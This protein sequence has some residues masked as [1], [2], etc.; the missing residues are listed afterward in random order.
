[1]PSA[2]RLLFGA[3]AC[4]MG[5]DVLLI[6]QKVPLQNP[7][8]WGVWV[9]YVI[10]FVFISAGVIA[11]IPRRQ[12]ATIQG[13]SEFDP[14]PVRRLSLYLFSQGAILLIGAYLGAQNFRGA[15]VDRVM[16]ATAAIVIIAVGLIVLLA[17]SNERVYRR[18]YSMAHVAGH[19]ILALLLLVP[20]ATFALLLTM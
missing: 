2:L 1:M 18:A 11:Y 4:F 17:S 3:S 6:M 12:P 20:I 10:A 13:Q 16:L 8:H 19:I 5:F 15:K 9:A 7:N 14:A